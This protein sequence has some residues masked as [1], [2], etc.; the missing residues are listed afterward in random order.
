GDDNDRKP[1]VQPHRPLTIRIPAR[2]PA[3]VRDESSV[4]DHAPSDNPTPTPDN[5]PVRNVTSAHDDETDNVNLRVRDDTAAEVGR[6]AGDAHQ[7]RTPPPTSGGMPRRAGKRR[8]SVLGDESRKRANTG[9]G[10]VDADREAHP[11][12]HLHTR[13]PDTDTDTYATGPVQISEFN[14]LGGHN[15][16]SAIQCGECAK[17]DVPCQW[18]LQKNFSCETCRKEHISCSLRPI[19]SRTGDTVRTNQATRFLIAFHYQ[20]MWDR[21]TGKPLPDSSMTGPAVPEPAGKVPKARRKEK[22]TKGKG[23]AESN[24]EGESKVAPVP[25]VS[26]GG[27]KRSL[28]GGSGVWVSLPPSRRSVRLQ[29]QTD[30]LEILEQRMARMEQ[31]LQE[32]LRAV[33]GSSEAPA[34]PAAGPSTHV[35]DQSQESPVHATSLPEGEV[36]PTHAPVAG[37]STQRRVAGRPRTPAAIAYYTAMASPPS[38]R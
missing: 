38:D 30:R 22:K 17:R 5:S 26:T 8:H 33:T 7:V 10:E 25:S 35:R 31:T 2:D 18:N 27:P 12:Q 37:P 16:T 19:G 15:V 23:K 3:T 9:P 36:T 13:F 34:V 11:D 29:P 21:S 14:C 24:V 4:G 20:L 32:I 1:Q 6:P 28:G